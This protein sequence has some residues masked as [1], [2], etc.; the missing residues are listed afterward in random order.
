MKINFKAFVPYIAVFAFFVGVAYF[1]TPQV[2]SGKIVNQ[3]DISSWRGMANEIITHN[4]AHPDDKTLWTG[5]MFGGMPATQVSVNFEGDYTKPIYD[6]LFT[7]ARPASYFLISLVGAFLLFLA[8]GVNLPL[9]VVGAIA[10]SFCSYNMQIIEAGHNAKMVAIAFMPWCLAAFVYAYRKKALLG[11]ILFAFA[12]SFQI[13]ANHPQI[14]YYLAFIVI[15]YSIAEFV[16][17]IKEKTLP[18]FFKTSVFLLVFGI[19]G[20][21]TNANNLIPTYE[22]TEYTMRGGSEL[23]SENNSTNSKGLDIEYATAWSYGIEETFNMMIPNLNGGSSNGSLD[24]GSEVYSVMK[25]KYQGAEQ[26][27]KQLPLYWGPQP[28][29]SGPMYLGALS[30]FLFVLGLVLYRGRYKWWIAAVTLVA[31][32]LAWGNHFMWFTE[33]F[34][35]Y[36]PLYNKF[37]TVSMALVVLQITVPLLGILIVNEL[38]FSNKEKNSADKKKV[39]TGFY[40]ALGCTAGLTLIFALFP[41]LLGSFTSAADASYPSDIASALS[42]DRKSL[43]RTDAIRTIIYI[44]LGASALWLGWSKKIKPTYAVAVLGVLIL[45]DLWSVDKRYLND[46]HFVRPSSWEQQYDKRPVDELILQDTDPNYRVLDLAVNTFNDSHTSYHHKTIGGY[47]AVKLQRYQ[48]M[49]E[50]C[51]TPEMQVLAQ[52]INAAA[53]ASQNIDS[54]SAAIGYHKTLSMLNTR[55]IIVSPNAPPLV[56]HHQLGNAWFIEKAITAENPNEEMAL[57]KEID[58]SKMAVLDSKSMDKYLAQATY[59]QAATMGKIEL[60]HYAP[61]RLKYKSSSDYAG[62]ALFSEV[63]YPAGWK[64]TIDGKEAP[65]LRANYIL[66]GLVIEEGEHEIEFVFD[67]QSFKLGEN[68]STIC[69][70]ILLLGLL[71][72]AFI[73]FRAAQLPL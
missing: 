64:A 67:P 62:L 66:R 32:F 56:N 53:S 47:S 65:I 46:S 49:I 42:D 13:K 37:R 69:S 40:I 29:T 38:L 48:D 54:I 3:A 10:V 16:K 5:S 22:Y 21:A 34:F 52:E 44:V 27:I 11:A 41:T 7:G 55:Y 18:K 73:Y 45:I 35:K 15:G 23:T 39:E 1:F 28:F 72:I 14:T 19:I 26:I 6:F 43:L 20:I 57:T 68:I 36:V 63:Y 50:H 12:L 24:R 58:P 17:A 25:G 60:T 4:T 70:L 30:I 8:F 2:F 71:F 31:I 9:A 59:P 33:L 51:I 61:N